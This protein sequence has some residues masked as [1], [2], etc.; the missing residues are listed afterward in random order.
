M[1]WTKVRFVFASAMNDIEID[2]SFS[3]HKENIGR[4]DNVRVSSHGRSLLELVR[5][6]LSDTS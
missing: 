6:A 3:E 4:C 2:A 5:F 1:S